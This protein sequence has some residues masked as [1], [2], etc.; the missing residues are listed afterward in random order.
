MRKEY[1][2]KQQEIQISKLTEILKKWNKK[3]N[4]FDENNKF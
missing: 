2:K 4:K 3:Q 1:E